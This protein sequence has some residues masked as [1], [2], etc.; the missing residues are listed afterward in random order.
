MLGVKSSGF[1]NFYDWETGTV[2][3]RIDV[4]AKSV[5]WSDAGDLVAIVCEESFYILRYNAQAY[6]QFIEN[7]G[8]PGLEGVEEA[9]EF[10][11]DIA[12][13]YIFC[14]VGSCS[15]YI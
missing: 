8:D 13:R 9:F 3:R 4:E 2:V 15:Y 14:S 7:G 5:F 12:E 1:L 6:A 10:E 11:N